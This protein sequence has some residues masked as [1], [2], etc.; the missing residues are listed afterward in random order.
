MKKSFGKEFQL[1]SEVALQEYCAALYLWGS[2][3]GGELLSHQMNRLSEYAHEKGWEIV[4]TYIDYEGM[5]GQEHPDLDRLVGD[6]RQCKFDVILAASLERILRG[7]DFALTLARNCCR[8]WFIW[9]RWIAKL[10]HWLG[11]PL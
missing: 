10:T 9:S 1:R 3:D 8:G 6:A 7:T 2:L 5:K 11:I 4:N